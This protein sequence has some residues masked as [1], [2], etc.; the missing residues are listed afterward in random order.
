MQDFKKI[1]EHFKEK[2]RA[3]ESRA[4]P[5]EAI[6][7]RLD[8]KNFSSL[9]RKFK[10]Q[11]ATALNPTF[12]EVMQKLCKLLCE[13]YTPLV[14]FVGSDEISLVFQN[15]APSE[16]PFGGR[17]QKLCSLV[18]AYTSYH[19][20]TLFREASLISGPD[21]VLFDCRVI[22]CDPLEV[23]SYL[24]SRA[25]DVHRN[26]LRTDAQRSLSHKQLMGL[27][28]S[29]IMAK[30]ERGELALSE[31]CVRYYGHVFR[32]EVKEV[33]LREHLG[34]EVFEGLL[35]KGYVKE[36]DIKCLKT[37]ERSDGQ[38]LFL[39]EYPTP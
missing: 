6:I 21:P 12:V 4:E 8:G 37:W 18:A 31:E 24:Q 32:R 2:E 7:L 35:S 19:A 17:V 30:H 25:Y 23:P 38:T 10:W 22:F 33:P 11:A 1:S 29:G 9:K 16:H 15:E 5:Q 36:T 28:D 3:L 14:A 13:E 20:T 34:Q 39:G 27:G 26:A